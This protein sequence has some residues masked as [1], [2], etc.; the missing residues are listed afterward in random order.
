VSKEKPVCPRCGSPNIS[1]DATATWDEATND[2]TL[3]GTYDAIY[4]PDCDKESKFADW[5]PVD[6]PE[7]ES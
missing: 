7:R 2:W 6:K 5:Q 1:C 4:C 3:A